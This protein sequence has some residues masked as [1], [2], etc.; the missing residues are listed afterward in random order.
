MIPFPNKKYRVI[1]ADPPWAYR[2]IKTGG[3][4]KSGAAQKYPTME[5]QEICSLP[6]KDISE[7]DSCLFLWATVPLL[8][9]GLEV[10]RAWEF[11]Y[12]T[13]VFWRKIM[14]LGLGYW[15]RGQVEICLIG[16]RGKIKPFRLQIS[17]FIQSKAEMHSKKP[18]VMYS[19][20]EST[21][22]EPKIELFAR[23]RRTGWDAWGLEVPDRNQSLISE[24]GL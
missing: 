23:E 17:N 24:F 10:M 5:L 2:N 14:S 7:D 16:I 6:V 1:Y 18:T 19:I 9:E 4:L 22:L 15:F 13:S 8:P 3:S 21:G 20:I 12:K 11:K